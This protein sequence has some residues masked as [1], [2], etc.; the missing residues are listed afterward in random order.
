MKKYIHH[1]TKDNI[2]TFTILVVN[3]DN[4]LDYMTVIIENF[5]FIN[6]TS[7]EFFKIYHGLEIDFIGL[8]PTKF[9]NIYKALDVKVI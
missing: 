1:N 8:I 4:T 3:D 7:Q 9:P 6:L 5:N 2:T